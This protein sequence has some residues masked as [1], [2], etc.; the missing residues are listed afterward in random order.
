[1]NC[2]IDTSHS[3]F[4]VVIDTYSN[5]PS[6]SPPVPLGATVILVCR[7]GGMMPDTNVQYEW[8]CPG[9]VCNRGNGRYPNRRTANNTLAVNVISES[10]AGSYSCTVKNGV[11]GSALGEA[12]S[13]LQ[14]SGQ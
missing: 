11:S 2:Y 6:L 12:V 13:E 3:P 9:N 10:D 7:V 5:T 1:M 4:S 8:S 14:I